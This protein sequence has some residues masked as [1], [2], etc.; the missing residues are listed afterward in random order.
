M[1]AENVMALCIISFVALIFIGIGISQYKSKEPVGFYS[2]E[3]PPREED[4]T[5]VRAWNRGHG[6]MWIRYGVMMIAA[7]GCGIFIKN[8]ALCAWITLVIL[9]GGLIGMFVGHHKLVKMYLR[10][11]DTKEQ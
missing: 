1:N 7:G 9:I 3:K 5:D 11:Y 6:A 4:L 10:K 8:E 2:G